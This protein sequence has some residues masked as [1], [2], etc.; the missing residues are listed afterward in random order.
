[1]NPKLK[2]I[3]ILALGWIFILLGIAGLFLPFLQGILFLLIGLYFLSHEFQWAER[4][5]NKIRTR[6]PS[7]A[8]KLDEAKE[9]AKN[10]LKNI[11][12]GG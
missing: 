2:R 10:L 4:L 5:L 7:I 6:Y 11:R 12:I 8:K 9:K 1:M 3:F